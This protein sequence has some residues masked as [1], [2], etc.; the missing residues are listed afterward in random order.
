MKEDE[1]EIVMKNVSFLSWNSGVKKEKETE[2]K[3]V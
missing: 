1:F 3:N 2:M